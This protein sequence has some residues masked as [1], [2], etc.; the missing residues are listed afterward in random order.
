MKIFKKN[1]KYALKYEICEKPTI[2]RLYYIKIYIENKSK[3]FFVILKKL[4]Y[5]QYI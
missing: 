4:K 1:H 3:F 2:Q 5:I